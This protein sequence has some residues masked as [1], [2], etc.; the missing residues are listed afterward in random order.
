VEEKISDE[1]RLDKA[2]LRGRKADP[3]LTYGEVKPLTGAVIVKIVSDYASQSHQTLDD[4][5][6]V[7]LGC[8]AC[9]RSFQIPQYLLLSLSV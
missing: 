6:L 7:D 2:K 8:G 4:V 1:V 9:F 5:V 3:N